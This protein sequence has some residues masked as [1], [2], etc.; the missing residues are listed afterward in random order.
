R[1]RFR[2]GG[3]RTSRHAGAR[4]TVSARL[5]V[6]QAGGLSGQSDRLAPCPT[7]ITYQATSPRAGVVELRTNLDPICHIFPVRGGIPFVWRETMDISTLIARTSVQPR[8]YQ[9]RIVAK[10]F[11][12]F[13]NHGL[14]SVLIDSPTGSGKTVMGLLIARALQE[15]M[16]VRIGWV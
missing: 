7:R 8:P 14:R 10:A 6:G 13:H 9:Q 3:A 16:G 15:A 11:D 2:Q 4:R 12:H 5:F 1:L